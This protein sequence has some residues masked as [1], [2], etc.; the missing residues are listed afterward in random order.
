ME[1]IVLSSNDTVSDP[2][3][4]NTNN[5]LYCV[6]KSKNRKKVFGKSTSWKD[7]DSEGIIYNA[8]K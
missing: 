1:N 5:A 6:Q 4:L 2:I 3:S 7:T 8:I